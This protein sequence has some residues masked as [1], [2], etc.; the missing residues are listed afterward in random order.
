MKRVFVI[1]L[2]LLCTAFVP[3]PAQAAL[4]AVGP[5]SADNGFPVWYED[6]NALRLD[7]C[8]DT[9]FCLLELPTPALPVS[10]PDNFGPEAFWYAAESFAVG[11]GINGLL[12][13]AL[14]AAFVNE[15]PV[16]GDQ[17][18]FARIRIILDVPVNGNYT[19]TH[20]YGVITFPNVTAADGIVVTQDIGNFG[21]P[22]RLGD[23]SI[24]LGD[25]A[26][27]AGTVNAD[28]RSIGPF[29]TPV[30]GF[31]VDP[32]SGNTYIG[33][34]LSP[35]AVTGSPLGTNFFRVEG[36]GGI[37]AETT[38]FTLAGKV[39]GCTD[40]NLAPV[41]VADTAATR[42]G[43]AA[44]INV[45]ANDSDD[46]ALNPATIAINVAPT[47]GTAVANIDGTVTYTPNALFSGTDSFT[48]TV[49]DFCAL[50][51]NVVTATIVVEDLQTATADYR[52]RTGRWTLEGSSSEPFDPLAQPNVITL[53][54]GGSTG[55]VIGTAQVQ[56]DGSW[57]FSGK[58]PVSPGAAPHTIHVDSGF[59][60]TMSEP[61]Q[62]R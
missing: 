28:G 15:G 62:L 43:T 40:G 18:A 14:E 59:G 11:D 17:V 2:L 41:A 31:V 23:Y 37:L 45:L 32:I 39:S 48:Y 44:N 6:T 20:P 30:A 55:A 53:R 36:P 47:N 1:A 49:Q 9:G 61:L 8:L 26:A 10:F 16:E 58:S 54:V 57:S 60:V 12:I 29:L 13:L 42:I 21:D 5:V 51:S 25:D 50:T 4:Q 46:A 3:P 34:P 56:G 7:L 35:E 24:A 22:G 38:T 33:S 52:A 27:Q 19:V